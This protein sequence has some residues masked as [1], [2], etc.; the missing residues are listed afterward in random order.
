MLNPRADASTEAREEDEPPAV[1]KRITKRRW[2]SS[3]SEG[4]GRLDCRSE[5][6]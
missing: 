5:G 2:N 3:A 1:S 4:E 6:R